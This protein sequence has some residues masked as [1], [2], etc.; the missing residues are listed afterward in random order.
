MQE[1][2]FRRPA[3]RSHRRRPKGRPCIGFNARARTRE[4][5]L[6]F[7]MVMAL[8]TIVMTAPVTVSIMLVVVLGMMVMAA[9]VSMIVVMS[10]VALVGLERRHDL[11]ATQSMRRHQRCD[12]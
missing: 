9:P 6:L 10:G 12:L 11:R 2:T 7:V 3:R 1:R 8:M 5:L 4:L